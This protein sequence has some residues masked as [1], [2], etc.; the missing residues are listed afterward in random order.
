MLPPQSARSGLVLY[1]CGLIF[2]LGIVQVSV[3]QTISRTGPETA[4][5]GTRSGEQVWP[6]IS[7]GADG[8]YVVW[9]DN[10]LEPGGGRGIAAV[11][12]G[13]N[14]APTG[15]P[16]RVNNQTAGNQEK[17]QSV[18]LA[19]GG[20][21]V[22]WESRNGGK[23]GLYGR[24]LA[25]SGGFSSEEFQ[26]HPAWTNVTIKQ[27]VQWSG[28]FRNKAKTRTF[29]FREKLATV[30][31][32]S[33]GVSLVALPDGG[34]V[35]LYHGVRRTYTNTFAL[36]RERKWNGVRST[37]NDFLRPVRYVG[38]WMQDVYWQRFDA[39]GNKVGAE[40]QVNQYDSFNQRNPSA[41]LLAN[42][43][44]MVVW[45]SEQPET[46]LASDNFSI[47]LFGR[48]MTASGEPVSDEFS[49][50]ADSR[51]AAA[52][53][54]VTA[55]GNGFAVYWSQ[56]ERL[57]SGNWDVYGRVFLSASQPAGEPFLVNVH[58]ERDQYGPR[59]ASSGAIQFV[60]W[61]SLG[62]D[63]SREG[64]YA[65]AMVNGVPAGNEVQVNTKIASHQFQPVVSSA[66]SGRIIAIWS[67]FS[68]SS[69]LDLFSQVFTENPAAQ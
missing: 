9:E 58:T 4:L 21:F 64:V 63:G 19:G 27:T 40:V 52:N 11:H 35:V 12:L 3:A 60:L 41:T 1:I 50:G 5:L 68:G 61:T 2:S 59:V 53:P 46:G 34:A 65:R 24:V 14:L 43:N 47:A 23:N 42:G 69:G 57:T 39:T 10:S 51:R 33:G 13:A 32:H 45:V 62:Q 49:L 17:P 44:V 22:T 54:V 67:G 38:D 16:F 28:I 15:A 26:I 36:V 25:A 37:T 55:M 29:K 8:G 31:E 18:Q 56:H 7:V 66:G 48:E 20:A 30:R 6:S